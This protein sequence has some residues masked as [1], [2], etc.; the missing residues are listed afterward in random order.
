VCSGIASTRKN[1]IN[2]RRIF[3]PVGDDPINLGA[4]DF[5]RIAATARKV[6]GVTGMWIDL[7]RVGKVVP[8]LTSQ[9]AR[10][11]TRG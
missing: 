6:T 10:N 3:N 2:V 1:K 4:A 9:R 8:F 5:S 11:E 7:H